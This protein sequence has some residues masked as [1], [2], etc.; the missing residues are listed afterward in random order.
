MAVL[1]HLGDQDAGPAA[2]PL[3]EIVD[4]RVDAGHAAFHATHLRLIDTGDRRDVGPVPAEHLL[5]RV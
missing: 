2:L 1:A 4:Q 3:L 5:E